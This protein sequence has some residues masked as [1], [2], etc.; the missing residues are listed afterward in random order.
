MICIERFV[1]T[2][3]VKSDVVRGDQP[4][5]LISFL[6]QVLRVLLAL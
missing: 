4:D 1:W 6:Q 5:L 2:A 3:L